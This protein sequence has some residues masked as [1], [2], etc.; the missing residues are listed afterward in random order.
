MR[1]LRLCLR[2]VWGLPARL[3]GS[4]NG[5][6]LT[7]RHAFAAIAVVA[8]LLGAGGIAGLALIDRASDSARADL[9]VS[10]AE[11]AALTE[12]A[13]VNACGLINLDRASV[14]DVLTR[15]GAAEEAGRFPTIDCPLYARTGDVVKAREQRPGREQG[16]PGVPIPR[17]EAAPPA[18]ASGDR[19]PAGP[20]GVP[21]ARGPKG[22]RGARGPRGEQGEPGLTVTGPAGPSGAPGEKGDRGEKGEKGEP[23][24]SAD[25]A[26]LAD[27]T[28]R[29]QAVEASLALLAGVLPR[30]DSL[31]ARVGALEALVAPPPPP[32][33]LPVP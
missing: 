24:T 13:L 19:G 2:W 33:L 18:P 23:G 14:R 11:Q 7:R 10:A 17:G 26:A 31:E 27:L 6:P 32:P 5:Q 30:L 29:L 16:D 8:A 25:A 3:W 15:R 22:D 28:A 12:K 1:R 21:G 4:I 9:A 20:M